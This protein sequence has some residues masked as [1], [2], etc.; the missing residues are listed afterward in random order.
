[1]A[2]IIPLE[3][4]RRRAPTPPLRPDRPAVVVIF[5]GV[6]YERQR[7]DGP[8]GAAPRQRKPPKAN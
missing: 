7:D 1:M 8:A 4:R 5:P 2:E 6:R 3:S